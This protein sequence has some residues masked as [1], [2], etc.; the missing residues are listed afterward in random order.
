MSYDD[1]LAERVR[2]LLVNVGGG[3][4]DISE[5]RMFGGLCFM[6]NGNMALGVHDADLIVRFDPSETAATLARPYARPFDLSGTRSPPRGWGLVA[7]EGTRTKRALEA[8]MD[9]GLR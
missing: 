6:L 1:R 2:D 4:E 9:K 3:E 7:P 8:W 5:R